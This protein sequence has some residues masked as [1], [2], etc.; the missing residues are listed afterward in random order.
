MTEFASLPMDSLSDE[1]VLA[2]VKQLKDTLGT[3]GKDE[4][5]IKQLLSGY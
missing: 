3:A 1:E 5:L 2:R 4:P